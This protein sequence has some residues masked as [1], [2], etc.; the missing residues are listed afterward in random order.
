M[1]IKYSFLNLCDERLLVIDSD[2]IHECRVI[3]GN[4][5]SGVVE[6]GLA[7]KSIF[8][9]INE[10]TK[11][12][13]YHG[14]IYTY[15]IA[16]FIDKLCLFKFWASNTTQ[17]DATRIQNQFLAIVSHECRQPLTAI[18]NISENMQDSL[19]TNEQGDNCRT[20]V[21]SGYL[22]LT[23]LNDLLDYSK[24]EAGKLELEQSAVNF[25]DCLSRSIRMADPQSKKKGIAVYKQIPSHFMIFLG[26]ES[27]IQQILNN[28]ITN[29][30]K[31]TTNGGSINCKVTVHIK[32]PNVGG[33]VVDDTDFERQQFASPTLHSHLKSKLK[34]PSQPCHY[35]LCEINDTGIGIPEE[36]F[37][38]LFRP[39]QQ[40]DV[41]T[42]KNHLGSGLGLSICHKLVTM[43]GGKIGVKSKMKEGSCFWFYLPLKKVPEDL[44]EKQM[45]EKLMSLTDEEMCAM[46][47]KIRI[48]VVDDNVVN[49]ELMMKTLMKLSFKDVQ[50]SENGEQC[51]EI[52]YRERKT[53]QPLHIIL[54]D[55]ILP[56]SN[57][58]RICNEI[59][60]HEKSSSDSQ[61]IIISVSGNVVG[62][63]EK[64]VELGYNDY[65][66]KPF[67][68][69]SFTKLLNIYTVQINNQQIIS[70]HQKHHK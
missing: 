23:I 9:N 39:F 54:L 21:S 26:D 51:M 55:Q 11:K 46:R 14:T 53:E 35:L 52:Y 34:L 22:M 25:H 47:N 24:I 49:R 18:I 43:M 62:R 40:A 69:E 31:F 32:E 37:D 63:Q 58:D 57:G 16:H 12:V 38:K 45:T 60:V 6:R 28:L 65:I 67:K 27:R 56:D 2:D 1:E 70:L 8:F 33:Y 44:Q 15:K 7:F 13:E 68:K 50:T 19:L 48:L 61:T 66:L 29:A 36:R 41:T 10:D 3:F 64:Y 59:R 4:V 30:I 17:T 20:I 5:A 42:Y